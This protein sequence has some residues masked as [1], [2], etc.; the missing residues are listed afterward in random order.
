MY[1]VIDIDNNPYSLSRK[2]ANV[3]V[4]SEGSGAG[5]DSNPVLSLPLI[6]DCGQTAG[7]FWASAFLPIG[8][9]A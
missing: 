7:P 5:L 8:V 9:G 4:V 3:M 2:S 6:C 1:Q